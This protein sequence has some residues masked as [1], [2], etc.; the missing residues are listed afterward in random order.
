MI[1]SLQLYGGRFSATL[2]M[3][4]YC[5]SI[6]VA[7]YFDY[8]SILVG[9]VRTKLR[10]TLTSDILTSKQLVVKIHCLK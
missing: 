3:L 8:N 5:N 1:K 4:P 9:R 7:F 10:L 6:P 2:N